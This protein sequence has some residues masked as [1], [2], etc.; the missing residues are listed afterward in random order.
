MRTSLSGIA[1]LLL[2]AGTGAGCG[3]KGSDTG[4][5]PG[6]SVFTEVAITPASATIFTV[7]PGNA[8]TLSAVAKDQD[9]DTLIGAGP[10]SFSSDNAAIADVSADG[11]VTAAAPGLARI[12]ASLTADGVTKTGTATVTALV[13]LQN[14]GVL[15]PATT[16]EPAIANMRPGGVVIWSFGSVVHDVVFTTPGAPENVP[17]FAGGFASRTFPTSGTY[18]YECTLHPGMTG[19]VQVH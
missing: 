1:T 2:V 17:A 5:A 12:T 10:A 16:F 15:A 9:G 7:A 18:S 6:A 13:A 19:V 8:V 3:D 4:T 14:A 11:I